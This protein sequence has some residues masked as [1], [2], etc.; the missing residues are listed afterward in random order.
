MMGES[1]VFSKVPLSSL[2]NIVSESRTASLC[3]TIDEKFKLLVTMISSNVIRIRP[4]FKSRVK[5][6]KLGAVTSSM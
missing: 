6:I 4:E 2:K 1:V 3:I 5:L